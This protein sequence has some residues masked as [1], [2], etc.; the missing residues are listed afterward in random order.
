MAART[1]KTAVQSDY[2]SPIIRLRSASLKTR[3]FIGKFLGG[4]IVSVL[5]FR[6]ENAVRIFRPR[7]FR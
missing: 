5:R 3:K 6:A 1:R 4:G 7:D 2:V